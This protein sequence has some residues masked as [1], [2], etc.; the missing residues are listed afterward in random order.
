M[1]LNKVLQPRTCS[2]T[3]FSVTAADVK[4]SFPIV[5]EQSDHRDCSTVMD[6]LHTRNYSGSRYLTSESNYL[7]ICSPHSLF[8]IFQFVDGAAVPADRIP[9]LKLCKQQTAVCGFST[10]SLFSSEYVTLVQITITAQIAGGRDWFFFT[11]YLSHN[12]HNIVTVLPKIEKLILFLNKSY[13][14][15]CQTWSLTYSGSIHADQKP[16]CFIHDS[17]VYLSVLICFT[18]LH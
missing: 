14:L 4:D 9:L 10:I 17:I 12:C 15:H 8:N 5:T 16:M 18:M 6:P 11:G 13:I 3:L 7:T 2:S 1:H